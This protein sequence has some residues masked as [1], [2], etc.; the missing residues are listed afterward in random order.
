MADTTLEQ[1]VYRLLSDWHGLDS[2]KTLFWTELNYDRVNEP[3]STQDW[4][5]AAKDPLAGQPI[6]FAQ[7]GE[8]GQFKVLYA[9]LAGDRLRLTG[10]RAVVN[11]LLRDHP[12]AL[13]IF[14]DVNQKHWH[15]VNVKDGGRRLALATEDPAR[16]PRLLFRRISLGPGERVRTAAQRLSLLDT[17]PMPKGLFGIPILAM[18]AAHDTAFDVEAVTREFFARY[19]SVFAKVEDQV[20]NVGIAETKRLFVQRLFNRLMFV[21]FIQKKGWLT[22]KGDSDYLLALWRDYQKDQSDDKNFYRDRL[23]PLFF[24]GLN[25]PHEQN[26]V[27]INRGRDFLST[28]IGNVPYL[29]G[30]LFEEA[31]G[32]HEADVP[33]SAIEPILTGLF[34]R[35]NFTITESTPFDVE[36]AVD[37]EMLGRIFEELVTG[38]HESGSYYTPKPVVSFMCREGLKGYLHTANPREPIEA[39]T[40]FVEDRDAAALR[41]PETV[42]TALRAVRAC[43]PACGSGAYLLGLLHELLDLRAALFAARRLDARTVYERKL[44]IIQRNL[45]GV[46]KDEFA[47][48]IARLRLWLSLVVDYEGDDP[49]PLP[50]LDFKIETGDSLTA[51][52]PSDPL[53]L[54]MFRQAQLKEFYALKE[55]YL[56][57]HHGQKVDLKRR[58]ESL[59]GVIA[60]WAHPIAKGQTQALPGLDWAVEFAEVF[61]PEQA[62]GAGGFDIVL[63]NPPYVRADAP[64]RHIADEPSRQQEIAEWQ[65]YRRQLKG[66]PTYHT[67]HEK[68]DLFIPFLER[69]HQLL[70]GGGQMVFII[71]DAYNAAKYAGKSHDFFLHNSRVERIDFCSEIDLFDAGVNNT[72]IHFERGVPPTAHCPVRV[73]RWGKRDEFDSNQEIL[74]TSGQAEYS[75]SLF[76]IDGEV[77]SDPA[78]KVVSLDAICYVSKGMVIHADERRGQGLFKAVDLVVDSRDEKHPKPYVEGK[79][80]GRWGFRRIRYLEYGTERAPSMFSRPTFIELHEPPEKLLALRMSGE[81]TAVA[82]DNRQLLSN[83]TMIVCVPWHALRGITNR[84]ISKEAEY[85]RQSPEG[86]RED[87]EKLSQGFLLK[88]VLAVMNSTSAQKYL[89]RIRQGKTD[90]FPDE[91]KQLPIAPLSLEAQQPFVE[92]V[93]AILSEYNRHGFPLPPEAAQRVKSLENELDEMVAKLYE[94]SL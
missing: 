21:A 77:R 68:W 12:N 41:D 19:A 83:H 88:Y 20:N 76:R 9:R 32:D 3:V 22:F 72:I 14:S 2:L 18:Q 43:D 49:P 6:I 86:D 92:K 1:A 31:D 39:L 42:L 94:V 79:D 17:A 23:Y 56:T 11:R 27:G 48:N 67:L 35:F 78:S 60:A 65:A 89:I 66:A 5:G 69:A 46:D 85:R 91:W 59:H 25:T 64:F 52:D 87:R 73:R 90:I 62:P 81:R 16:Q 26:L 58:I 70:Q 51:P 61:A 47:V 45:Y 29:N 4:P 54:D 55:Q 75:V 82:Y 71:P 15:L 50:N 80:A 84:S 63:A 8:G 36:V 93:D 57:A 37:P 53:K 44:E 24:L 10:E 28:L 7:A 38:R 33:D 40:R 13:F 34:Y 30:G 74:S